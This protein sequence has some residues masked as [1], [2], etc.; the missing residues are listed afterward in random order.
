MTMLTKEQVEL[1]TELEATLIDL[2][3]LPNETPGVQWD[4]YT[5]YVTGA[6]IDCV[7]GDVP[8]DIITM[9]F[10]AHGKPVP[11]NPLIN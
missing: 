9:C 4:Y 7:R 1:L 5:K 10:E 3:T 8:M 6:T 2:E 11:S